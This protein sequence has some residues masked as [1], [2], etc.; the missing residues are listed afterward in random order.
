M[1]D[2]TET[3]VG[4]FCPF[5]Y[6]KGLPERSR[7]AGG[8]VPVYG[9][10]GLVGRHDVAATEGSTVI[11]GRKGSV[12]VV[13]Y[14]A[15]PCWPID[16]T[17][18]I[19][20]ADRERLKFKYYLLKSLPLSTMNADSAVP[21][22]NRTAAH[23]LRVRIPPL[24]TQRR[25]AQILG[26]LDDKIELNRRMNATLEAMARALFKSWFVDFDPVRAKAAGRDSGLPAPL[27]ALFPARLVE[28]AL[29]DVPEGWGVGR[30]ED[31]TV[32]QRGF[33]LP[34]QQRIPGE[35]PVLAAS[36][37]NGT[38]C[39]YMVKGPGVTTGRSGVLGNVFYVH[40][41]FWP[42][43]TSLWVKEFRACGPAYAYYML[44]R[45][46]TAT[47]NAGSA[48][49]TLNRNHIHT[50]P[51]LLPP[52]ALTGHFEEVALSLLRKQKQN[53]EQ[54]A[55]LALLRDALLPRLLAGEIDVSI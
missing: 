49:P 22:L 21:G 24:P 29:G 40:E 9:S 23:S 26:T 45:L 47:Y 18:Y 4:E 19:T 33:D 7:V 52:R 31:L 42:L 39:E 51:A 12:G 14:S 54:S 38:H 28:S 30:L 43:N 46:D 50:L 5:A 32:L 6:G 2:W 41:D 48:V 44:E 10:N 53:D 27:A 11:V 15:E 20:D 37:P 55:T 35:Y 3:T 36:G 17:F 16:T 34:S 8:N 25:I 13:H 1:T